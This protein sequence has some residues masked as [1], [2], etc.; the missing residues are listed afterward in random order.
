LLLFNVPITV[1]LGLSQERKH[2]THHDDAR[3]GRWC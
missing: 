3:P 2:F 1:T